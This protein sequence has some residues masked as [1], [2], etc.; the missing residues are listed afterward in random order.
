MWRV[1]AVSVDN[2]LSTGYTSIALWTTGNEAAGRVDVIFCV[3][4]EEFRRNGVLDNLFFDFRTQL[5]VGDVGIV[6]RRNDDG[7]K[8]E[9][10]PVTIFNSYLR[11]AI[12][13]KIGQFA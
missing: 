7:F 11:L 9:R 3:F 8:T 10:T 1:A 5:L 13:S 4:V 2:D 6:L 12:G